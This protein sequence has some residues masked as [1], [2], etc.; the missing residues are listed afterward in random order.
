M[1]LSEGPGADSTDAPSVGLA[2]DGGACAPPQAGPGA[3]PGGWGL[4]TTGED[5]ATAGLGVPLLAMKSA[6]LSR[7][8][9]LLGGAG[10]TGAPLATPAAPTTEEDEGCAARASKGDGAPPGAR[11]QA[12]CS[13]GQGHVIVH[14]AAM[15]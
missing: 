8:P 10:V 5:L 13:R 11:L 6:R 4:T 1:S 9:E 3:A 2:P 15:L 14:V 7:T 12:P